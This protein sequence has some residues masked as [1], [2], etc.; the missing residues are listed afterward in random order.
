MVWD[1][2]EEEKVMDVD[3]RRKGAA[4]VGG[5]IDV[6]VDEPLDYFHATLFYF[7][8]FGHVFHV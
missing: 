8:P 4:T 1:D 7:L 5:S 2:E 3:R 6:E